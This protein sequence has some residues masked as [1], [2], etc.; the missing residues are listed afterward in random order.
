MSRYTSS[1]VIS[2]Y[3]FFLFAIILFSSHAFADLFKYED[4]DG[5]THYVDSLEKVPEKYRDQ[6]KEQ[7]FPG[8]SKVSA[9]N[10]V[11]SQKL[12]EVTEVKEVEGSVQN[13]KVVPEEVVTP[14]VVSQEVQAKPK[15]PAISNAKLEVFVADWCPHCRALEETLKKENIKYTRHDIESEDGKKLYNELGRGGVPITRINGK[16]IIRGNNIGKIKEAL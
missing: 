8:I 15:A 13:V 5:R 7:E 14:P 12:E 6:L 3:S 11:P 1:V 10:S 16:T 4:S 9:P 2:S